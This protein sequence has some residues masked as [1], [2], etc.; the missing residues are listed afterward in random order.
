MEKPSKTPPNKT[1][2]KRQQRLVNTVD[3]S[4]LTKSEIEKVRVMLREEFEVFATDDTDIDNVG[5]NMKR[6]LKDDIPYQVIYNS[7]P[8]SLYQELKPYGEDLLNKQWITNSH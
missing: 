4:G 1:N 5:H 7:I 2:S 6:R 3:P 8:H